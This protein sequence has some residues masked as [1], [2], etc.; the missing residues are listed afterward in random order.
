MSIH[1]IILTLFMTY[2]YL[3]IFSIPRVAH[4]T[5]ALTDASTV[6]WC[7]RWRLLDYVARSL[8]HE[9]AQFGAK[10]LHERA[11]TDA[12]GVPSRP[13]SDSRH[14]F[15]NTLTL[16]V[17]VMS[18]YG[19]FHGG[20]KLLEVALQKEVDLCRSAL[21]LVS[22]LFSENSPLS[23][24]LMLPHQFIHWVTCLLVQAKPP[25][26]IPNF[27]ATE[28]RVPLALRNAICVCV[29]VLVLPSALRTLQVASLQSIRSQASIIAAVAPSSPSLPDPQRAVAEALLGAYQALERVPASQDAAAQEQLSAGWTSNGPDVAAGIEM[30]GVSAFTQGRRI[31]KVLHYFYCCLLKLEC[32]NCI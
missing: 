5:A 4:L 27:I 9:S 10:L 1:E 25:A 16:A 13:R 26:G 7:R 12:T 29:A 15:S 21:S 22:G 20:T 23:A 6:A 19:W 11:W 30:C 14:T 8:S 24:A 31:L 18:F 32:N 3:S 2:Y 17:L 28:Q